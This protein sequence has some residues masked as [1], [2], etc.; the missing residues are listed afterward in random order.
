[1]NFWAS[2]EMTNEFL[3]LH[4]AIS[5]QPRRTQPQA[6]LKLGQRLAGN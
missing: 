2:L 4:R 5:C 1:M 3:Y 6:D